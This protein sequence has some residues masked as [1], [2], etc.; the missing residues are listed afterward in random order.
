[1]SN[2]SVTIGHAE[3]LTFSCFISSFRNFAVVPKVRSLEMRKNLTLN[4]ARLGDVMKKRTENNKEYE[5]QI[6]VFVVMCP[7]EHTFLLL[8]FPTAQR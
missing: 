5:T 6:I 7:V 4:W 3:V 8:N 1:M 2:R